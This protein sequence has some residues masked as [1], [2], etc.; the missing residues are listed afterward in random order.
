MRHKRR[1][2]VVAGCALAL[3][4]LI[5][6]A[7]A[8]AEKHRNRSATPVFDL[9]LRSQEEVPRVSGL[10]ADARGSVT[11]DL[12]RNSAGAITSGEVVFYVNYDFAGP[13]TVSGLHI[14]QGRR[15]TNGPIVVDSGVANVVEPDGDGNVTTVVA[16]VSPALLQAILDSPRDYYVN[17]H[18]T[19]HPAGAMR[20]QLGD[21]G[22]RGGG[23][24]KDND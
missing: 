17:L 9:Q 5:P 10:R 4:A 2:A 11:L 7:S 20:D 15:G 13:V 14:H 21:S 12:T 22:G 24:G 19:D 3:A 6:A 16:G 1:I 18:T 8:I 23:G